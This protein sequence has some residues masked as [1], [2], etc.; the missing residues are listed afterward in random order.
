MKAPPVVVTLRVVTV[1]AGALLFG[2]SALV[3]LLFLGLS[4]MCMD[5]FDDSDCTAWQLQALIPVSIGAVVLVLA[6]G[7]LVTRRT[8][9]VKSLAAIV[10]VITALGIITLALLF[11]G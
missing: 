5:D 9:V 3:S 11:T 2:V 10:G 8:G 1:L 7:T 4:S 6:L